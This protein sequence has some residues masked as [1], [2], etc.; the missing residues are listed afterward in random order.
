MSLKYSLP[1]LSICIATFNR[2]GF[3]GATLDSILSQVTPDVEVLVLDG[4]SP[5]N[6]AQVMA[7]Y[8]AK[9]AEL[10][11]IREKT[12]SGV[13]ADFDK[14]VGF[15]WGEFCW[16]M[17]DDDL[18]LP[19]AVQRVL[20]EL[21]DDRDLVIANAEVRN[22]D[23]SKILAPRQLDISE[24]RRYGKTESE[25]F[26]SECLNYL[27]FI[28][29]VIIRRARWLERDRK[30][31]YGSLFIHV[32]VICQSEPIS[33]V[34]VIAKPLI[35]I[36]YGNA[37]WT[38]RAFEISNFK[39]PDLVWSFDAFSD[40]AKRNVCPRAPWKRIRTL[41][42]SRATGA[43]SSVE[44]EM[45]IKNRTKGIRRLMSYTLAVFPPRLANFISIFY[46]AVL[47]R[48]AKAMQYDI[49]RSSHATVLS[50]AL[51]KVLWK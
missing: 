23:F 33:N 37:M 51:A 14:A 27:S 20:A 13:D 6:T 7:P 18:L 41:F 44:Y 43:Y 50:R 45:F 31:Y 1:K 28:G 47:N 30:T 2:G 3:I 26:Y 16:L 11:Y 35:L 39:W 24:D 34:F 15:A 8:L 29:G 36:R 10:R 17:T 32:G 48:A 12:N 40:V 49:L 38:P 25:R 46:F 19:G 4:A 21:K 42:Y 9:H 22:A 5:D